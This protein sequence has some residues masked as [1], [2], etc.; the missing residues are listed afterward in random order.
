MK[1]ICI[2]RNYAA[3]VKELNNAMPTKPLIFMKPSTAL[4]INDGDFYYPEYSKDIH[5]EAELVIKIAKNGTHV[6][7]KFALDYVQEIS[8][9]LDMTARDIQE[10]CKKK[11][12]PWEIAKAFDRS[13]VVGKFIPQTAPLDD[14]S[15][16]LK[17]NGEV[18]QKGRT[19]DMIFPIKDII[20]YVSQFFKL[21][22]GDMI[23]TGTPAGVG[24]IQIGDL[25][26]G[27]V[28]DEKVL[29]C[30]IK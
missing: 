21:Q 7:P 4:L 18:V 22:I 26:E 17:K 28:E 13:A 1:I 16:V 19:D 9:G 6:Q 30:Q 29:H 24:P 20:V 23:F 5:Y 14:T 3:H 15:F 25:F 11:G 27:Y 2:G 8:L 12:H 10:E